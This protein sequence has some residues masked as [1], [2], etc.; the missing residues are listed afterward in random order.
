M[1]L[2]NQSLIMTFLGL[3]LSVLLIAVSYHFSL[4]NWVEYLGAFCFFVFVVVLCF[5]MYIDDTYKK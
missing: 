2:K 4:P 5:E 1:S 3:A